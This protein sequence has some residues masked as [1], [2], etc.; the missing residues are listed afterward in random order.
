VHL[1][2]PV[3]NEQGSGK[4]HEDPRDVG[5]LAFRWPV[6]FVSK[7][8]RVT[9]WVVVLV[10]TSGAAFGSISYLA[11]VRLVPELSFLDLLRSPSGNEAI[12]GC[13]VEYALRSH[14]AN[15]LLFIGDRTCERSGG[16]QK[17]VSG[18]SRRSTS[19]VS[20]KV[21]AVQSTSLSRSIDLTNLRPSI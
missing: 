15:D 1:A 6:R 14:D 9:V 20:S 8:L 2:G 7:R 10:C 17:V 16:T 11:A 21:P 18:F 13:A 4:R 12:Y 3:A 5:K 19:A